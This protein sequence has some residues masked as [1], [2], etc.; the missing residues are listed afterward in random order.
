ME[1]VYG[2]QWQICSFEFFS[3][4]RIDLVNIEC[5][6]HKI[7]KMVLLLLLSTINIT[8]KKDGI[9]IV[10]CTPQLMIDLF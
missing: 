8:N 10:K 2:W 3:S 7:I 9:F 1:D 5:G 6:K 4:S